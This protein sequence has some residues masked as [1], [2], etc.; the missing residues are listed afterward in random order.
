MTYKTNRFTMKLAK[1]KEIRL[2][3]IDIVAV[4]VIKLYEVKPYVL[5]KRES[6]QVRA[7]KKKFFHEVK[8]CTVKNKIRN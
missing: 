8:W 6:T 7:K 4:T 5:S 3:L 2:Q 1:R